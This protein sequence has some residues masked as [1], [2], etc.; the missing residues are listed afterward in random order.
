MVGTHDEEGVQL[1]H[2]LLHAVDIFGQFLVGLLLVRFRLLRLQPA[3][4]VAADDVLNLAYE[5]DEEEKAA[6]AHVDVDGLVLR[7]AGE[8][9]A[10]VAL[11]LR[12]GAD[13]L[14]PLDADGGLRGDDDVFADL[15]QA[16]EGLRELLDGGV[17][18]AHVGQHGVDPRRHLHR[19]RVPRVLA[20]VE[21]L[22]EGPLAND[23]IGP[24][25]EKVLE[26]LLRAFGHGLGGIFQ[27]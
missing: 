1:G 8:A 26:L 2:V 14:H 7:A 16:G 3:A 10:V 18:V 13:G 19:P 23:V 15:A 4:D 12:N 9:E 11:L 5:P 25:F 17:D 22:A 24:R 6:E 27:L 21:V 20:D